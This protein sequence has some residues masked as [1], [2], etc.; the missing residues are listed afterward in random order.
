MRVPGT[1]HMP[2]RLHVISAICIL[3]LVQQT[4]LGQ[5]SYQA[6][7]RGVVADSTGAVLPN[8]TITITEV[9]TN[10]TQTATTDRSGEYTLRALRPST[11]V[12]K[13]Q[14]AGFQTVE[15]KGVVLAVDQEASL[16][17]SLRPAGT[18]VEVQV[19]ET[20]PLLDTGSSS[21]GTDITNEYV[22]EI[23][24]LNRNFFGLVFLT[25]GVS[26]TAGT[27]TAD[28]YPAG[29]NFV[30]NGQRNA[31]AEVRIDGA[32][33]TAPEEGEG[34]NSNIYYE[35][36]VE[37]VQEF[38]VQ[39]N[40]FS[41]EFGS[42]G[43]TVVNMALKSGTNAF[44]G[45]G[46]WFGQRDAFDANDFFSNQA[47][48]PKPD[49]SRNQYGAS[50]GGPIRKNRTFFFVDMERVLETNP[51]NIVGTVPTVAERK[52]DFSQA[53]ITD[54]DSGSVVPNQIFN[55]FS[56]DSNGVRSQFS[57]NKIPQNMW[58]PVG[59]NIL[60]L[61]PLP[62]QPGNPDGTN[63]FRANT[64]NVSKGL[65]FDIK[66]DEQLSNRTHI[67]GRYSH[68]HSSN[69][70]PTVLADG[71]FND[72]NN[73]VTSVNNGGLQ[74]DWTLRPTLLLSSRFAIDYVHAPG[75]TTY[76]SATSVGFPSVLDTANGIAR[77][78]AIQV[79][80]PWTS[81]YDQCCVDTKLD[82]TLYSYSSTLAWAKGKHNIKFG[83]EQ[84]IFFNN[85]QEPNY[86][87][88]YFHFAQTVT[89]NVIGGFNPVQGN[90]FADILLG[91]GDY[92]GI[93]VDPMALNK[94][95]DTSFYVQDDFR[96]TPKLTL[97]LG[98]RYEWS[99]PYTERF[100]HIEFSDFTGNSGVNLDL[101]SGDPNLQALGLGPTTL[102]GITRFPTSSNRNV[103]V[104]RNNWAPRLGFAYQLTPQTVVRGGAGIY[105]GMNVA[106]NYQYVGTAFR[107]DGN[108]IF[109]K[110]DLNCQ[111][112]VRA[113]CQYATF[114]N[115]FPAGL[116]EP[117][118]TKYGP[119][120]E[121]GF[122]NQNDLGTTQAR[123][124]E[125]YQWSLGVQRLLPW[126]LVVSA[127]YSAN[128]S[129][130]LP[131]GGAS[132]ATTRNRDYIPS[133]L[134]RKFSQQG[135]CNDDGTV[136]FTQLYSYNNLHCLVTNP[137][138]SMFQGPNAVFNEPDSLYN[139]PQIPLINLLRPYPQ[140]DGYF[141]GLPIL[142][143]QSF[144]NA[145]QI[146]FQK[147][148]SHYIGFEGG[149][150]L[151]KSTDNSSAGRNAWVNGLAFDNPQE[152]DN[153]KAEHSISANDAT[154]RLAFAVI[155]DLPIGRGRWVGRDM[156]R[157]LDGVVGGWTLST[158]ITLQSGQPIDIGMSQPTLD[159]GNQRPDVT[160][161]PSSGVSAHHSAL[162]GQSIFNT[163]CF[164]V[165]GLEQPGNAPRYFSNLRTDGI[166]NIDLS[167]EKSFVPREGMRLEIR[168]EFFNFFNTPRFAM[169]DN[170]LEDSTFGQVSSTAH[171]STPRR[172]QIGVRFEF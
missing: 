26:E 68:L 7:V 3:L 107:K 114:E 74:F 149:Y 129:T 90:P 83:G 141:E 153:L 60:N 154:H 170:L 9:G 88:G 162:T 11:Y 168:G 158:I 130:H 99:T 76:P 137:F 89:E 58:D 65:Q 95:K 51:I 5:A 138:Y 6:Q 85:F 36:S 64:G 71:D 143:S 46:W 165:P 87:S 30:S 122:A 41:S 15:R 94:S 115:P 105:Y 33:I 160:C 169:P 135:N 59:Q 164:V 167:F 144:Y 103:P 48:L 133:A 86:A 1:E 77:M 159:D 98:L 152:L 161:N 35:P 20:A 109:T 45:S 127:D 21:L 157:I 120:A 29:T 32:L 112:G 146:R 93:G 13:V 151:S 49:H 82:H 111:T 119:L 53:L 4:L 18:S 57:G 78:P 43:G 121:W 37:A 10:L 100:N 67:A 139:D 23:P 172:G 42:N 124:A 142:G 171:G 73:Y 56:V 19:T 69:A 22:R 126:Q 116:P 148:T 62:N 61:Y 84:R 70:V 104:D 66:L 118:G 16:N 96:V 108:I 147:R 128:H 24:L 38:K 17:F 145:L 50:L 8:A 140:F 31:T 123:N 150:T 27:G 102:K 55:P 91:I 47:G 12:V 39:N 72:G 132:G 136:D 125:I 81:I 156:N 117:Q 63:N 34:G 79:D 163:N 44:H 113:D 131:W 40:A 101:S 110:N 14:A 25:A 155:G 97:N 166:H 92:G 106:T 75:F 54:P 2:G 80:S 134:R 52:G 28:D